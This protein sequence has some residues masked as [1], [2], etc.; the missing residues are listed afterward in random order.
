L[1]IE[2]PENKKDNL[3][4]RTLW[5]VRAI[6]IPPHYPNSTIPFYRTQL[7]WRFKI[8]GNNK[9]YLRLQVKYPILTKFWFSRQ[10]FI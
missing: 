6:F 7:L 4:I 3:R 1:N 10:I 2:H 8:T 5:H 9:T